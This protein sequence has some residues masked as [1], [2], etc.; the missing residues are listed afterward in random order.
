MYVCQTRNGKRFRNVEYLRLRDDKIEAIECFFGAQ[1][2][3]PS[4]VSAAERKAVLAYHYRTERALS[5]VPSDY[6]RP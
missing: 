3:F 2:S 4:A 5:I 1:S 6:F